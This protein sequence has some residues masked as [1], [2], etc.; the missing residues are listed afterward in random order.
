MKIKIVSSFLFTLI[1]A[2]SFGQAKL[3]AKEA[4]FIALEN[5]YKIQIAEKQ[6]EIAEK[7]NKWSE[8]GLFPTVTLSVA[9]NNA[10]QDNTNNPFTFTPFILLNQSFS[11]TLSANWNIFSG[12]AVKISKER[13]EQL[14]EQTKGNSLVIIESTIHDVLKAYYSAV[15][16]KER[17]G[18]YDVLKN[19]SRQRV[20][21]YELKDKYAKTTSLEL[22]QFRNQYLTDSTNY[23]LQEISY[24]NALRNLQLLMNPTEEAND[25]SFPELTDELKF[26]APLIDQTQAL[27]DLTTN[28]QNLK[29]QFIAL[30]LQKSATEYQR[31][32][33]YPTLSLQAGVAPSYSW[34]RKTSAMDTVINTQVLNY[35][36]NLSLRY[37]IFNNWKTKRAIE[38]S[39]IQEEIAQYNTESM[40]KTLSS[41]LL[42]L[43]D[44]Y[45]VRMQLV[46]LSETNLTYATKAW[47]LAQTKF[48]NGTLS[49]IEL[50]VYQNNYQTTLMQYY[51]N[52]YNRIDTYLEVYKMT[53]K[54]GLEY[55]KN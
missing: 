21:Y 30:E 25:G 28:N 23:L 27:S 11:P 18:L 4:V 15:L 51:E 17:L 53:G 12:F 29:N 6:V 49:S 7:N 20:N 43:L 31:S 42:N 47:E 8:A 38:V 24:K 52:L 14:E 44:M 5:N 10:I 2:V 35:Y 46:S 13:L 45:K 16:Q 39:K 34:I 48:D 36:G 3:S 9:N 32:F 40:E 19:Y 26:E 33:L 37:S 50:A 1:G 22:M 54:I 55:V 41:S